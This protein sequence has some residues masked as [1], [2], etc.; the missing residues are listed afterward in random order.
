L[1]NFTLWHM[2]CSRHPQCAQALAKVADDA[3]GQAQQ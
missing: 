2:P 3:T 1:A